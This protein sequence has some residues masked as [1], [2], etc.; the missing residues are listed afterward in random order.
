MYKDNYIKFRVSSNDKKEIKMIADS[1]GYDSVSD[2]LYSISLSGLSGKEKI[3]LFN[4]ITE[5]RM[6]NSRVENNINQIAKHLNTYKTLSETQ[7]EDYLKV[8]REFSDIR[9]IQ[10]VKLKSIL[11]F[12]Y[13]DKSKLYNMLDKKEIEQ[14]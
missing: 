8:F 4:K 12:L 5:F 11:K 1:L 7:F 10:N 9:E 2:Y 3:L 6:G 14:N 13:N